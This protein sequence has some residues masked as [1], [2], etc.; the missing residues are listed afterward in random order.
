MDRM[1]CVDIPALPL[2]VLLQ[3]HPDWRGQPAAVVDR[4]KPIGVIQWV[5]AAAREH[6]ILPGM[7]YATGLSISSEL[8]AGVVPEGKIAEVVAS[9]TPRLW[10]FTPNVEPS[11]R[12]PGV[13]WL[14]ASGL[15]RVF[16]SLSEWADS[17]QKDLR[18]AGFYAA[19]AVGF[20]RFGTYAA[21][22]AADENILFRS[23]SRERAHVRRVPIDRLDFNPALRDTLLKLGIETLGG[24]IDLPPAG[25]RRRFGPEAHALHQMARGDGWASLEPQAYREPAEQRVALDFPVTDRD[26]L[27]AFLESMLGKVIAIIEERH[28][29]VTA[30]YVDL[31]LDDKTEQAEHISPASATNDIAQLMHLLRLRMETVTLS[32]GV[33]ELTLRAEC[34]ST[35]EGQLEL[36]PNAPCRD[37]EAVYRA[38]AKIRAE[39]GQDA[40]VRAELHDGHLP[41]A[42]YSW[43]GIEEIPFP[44]PGDVPLRPLIR[45]IYSPPIKL[46]PRPR[47]EPDGWLVAGLSEGPVEEVIGPYVLNG[48][49]WTGEV[50]RAYHFVRVRSGRW[51]WIFHDQKRRRW[52]LQ[53]EVE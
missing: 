20:S 34:T 7:R 50:S 33:A 29:S 11:S 38:F 22:K 44:N 16:P 12:E 1:A 40:V 45:R 5:N 4:D 41:E 10:N 2:Q 26:Q 53:G 43:E 24:F 27:L 17:I 32:C 39:L 21:A 3:V 31:V 13:F 19:V 14:D 6:R 48:G 51:L 42:G 23:P 47:H 18:E 28:E 35:S 52:Y 36:L 8:R 49:W 9:I 30:L 25:I 46:P 37:L 15:S